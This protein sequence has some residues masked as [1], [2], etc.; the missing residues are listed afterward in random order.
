MFPTSAW[1]Q[2]PI[3]SLSCMYYQKARLEASCRMI[4]GDRYAW[5]VKREDLVK[6]TH[7]E[8]RKNDG[9]LFYRII[10]LKS[11]KGCPS[12][13]AIQKNVTKFITQAIKLLSESSF[14][15]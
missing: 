6:M 12:I 2:G 3:I 4:S 1:A 13:F 10:L 8:W 9:S 14:E 7:S 5:G 15:V 11:N